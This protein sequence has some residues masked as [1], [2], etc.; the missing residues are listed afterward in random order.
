MAETKNIKEHMPVMGSCGNRLGDVDHVE[1]DAIK[2]TKKSSPDGKHHFIPMN[3]VEKVDDSV[4][5]NK[6]CGEAKKEWKTDPSEA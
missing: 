2:L 4:R 3:W 1:G 5:L 6:D